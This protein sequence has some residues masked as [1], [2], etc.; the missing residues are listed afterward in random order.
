MSKKYILAAALAAVLPFCATTAW[1]DTPVGETQQNVMTSVQTFKPIEYKGYI[2]TVPTECV[3]ENGDA[4]TLKHPDGTF[5]ISI[6]HLSA[7]GTNQKRVL[8]LCKGLAAKM[9]LK[10]A[11]TEKVKIDGVNSAISKGTIEGSD[12]TILMMP[13]SGKEF[14]AIIMASPERKPWTDQF[15]RTVRKK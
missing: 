11:V 15:L 14:T 6:T 9:D 3:V 1:A 13:K 4:L 2:F 12:V 7:P 10:N 8:S 5:G